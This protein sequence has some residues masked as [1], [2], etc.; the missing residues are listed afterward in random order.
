MDLALTRSRAVILRDV[1]EWGE[2]GGGVRPPLP[3]HPWGGGGGY[4]VWGLVT[5]A[6]ALKCLAA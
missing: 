1:L 3:M 4:E 2:G 6:P 5:D